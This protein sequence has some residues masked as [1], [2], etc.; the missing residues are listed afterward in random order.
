MEQRINII[1]TVE[2]QK[3]EWKSIL[4]VLSLKA[5]CQDP[6]RIFLYLP[7]GEAAAL[8]EET[9]RFYEH[10]GVELQEVEIDPELGGKWAMKVIA[11]RQERPQGE[12]GVYLNPDT[13]LIKPLSFRAIYAQ[14][15]PGLVPADTSFWGSDEEWQKLYEKFKL[16]APS[17]SFMLNS[18][19]LFYPLYKSGIVLF[20]ERTAFQ[21]LW[22]AV[23]RRIVS[24]KL[25]RNGFRYI[26]RISLSVAAQYYEKEPVRLHEMYCYNVAAGACAKAKL[27]QYAYPK[28]ILNY[29]M[30]L[31]VAEDLV[32][33]SGLFSSFEEFLR[34]FGV[35]IDQKVKG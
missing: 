1:T 18:G 35:Q 3:S 32:K 12:V 25:I 17:K 26:D 10:A 6:H 24:D 15:R 19:E 34:F 20:G 22:H 14:G 27:V 5:F 16:P 28:S 13:F 29:K 30:R 11:V 2:P 8:K 4:L 31:A 9:R 33:K 21:Y 23:A 7:R